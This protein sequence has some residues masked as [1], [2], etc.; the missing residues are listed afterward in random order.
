[1]WAEVKKESDLA[2]AQK[3]KDMFEKVGVPTRI[4]PDAEGIDSKNVSGYRV[5]VSGER[6]HV[7][8]EILRSRG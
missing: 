6:V 2:A 8:N 7:I 5:L 1:M 4:L 3:W